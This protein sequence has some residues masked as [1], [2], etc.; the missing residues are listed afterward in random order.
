VSFTDFHPAHRFPAFDSSS[1]QAVGLWNTSLPQFGHFLRFLF[2]PLL[3]LLPE[4]LDAGGLFSL[5]AVLPLFA[6]MAFILSNIASIA[7]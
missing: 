2:V 1:R 7:Y 4:L 5:S 6:M 3:L